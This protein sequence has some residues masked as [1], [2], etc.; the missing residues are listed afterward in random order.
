MGLAQAH[1]GVTAE[2][3][4]TLDF[5]TPGYDDV[6]QD[7]DDFNSLSVNEAAA[8]FQYDVGL[9]EQDTIDGSSEEDSGED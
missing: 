2:Q 1:G 5:A 6:N 3:M 4:L 9:E 8:P 7:D